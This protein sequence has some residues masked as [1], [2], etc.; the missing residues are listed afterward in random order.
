MEWEPGDAYGDE[1][2]SHVVAE[3]QAGAE[4]ASFI[5]VAEAARRLGCDHKLIRE[6]IK[7]GEIPL[8]GTDRAHRVKWGDVL[9]CFERRPKHEREAS[10]SIERKPKRARGAG[11]FTALSREQLAKVRER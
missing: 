10:V 8:Y 9:A 1:E 2:I 5:T 3:R 6:R 4:R 11:E 7:R